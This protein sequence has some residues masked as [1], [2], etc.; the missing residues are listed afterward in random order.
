[1][2]SEGEIKMEEVTGKMTEEEGN[3][4]IGI[5]REKEVERGKQK[6]EERE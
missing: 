4:V 2:G 3:E 1:M 5:I 6:K